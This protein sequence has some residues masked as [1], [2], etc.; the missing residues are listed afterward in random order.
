MQQAGLGGSC[1]SSEH[2]P[3]TVPGKRARSLPSIQTQLKPAQAVGVGRLGG[4][5][6][7]IIQ[8][9]LPKATLMLFSI[10]ILQKKSLL[11]TAVLWGQ[12]HPV[13]GKGSSRP[14]W[15]FN[16]SATVVYQHGT[17]FN[18]MA[19]KQPHGGASTLKHFLQGTT[20]VRS[21]ASFL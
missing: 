15:A 8:I 10:L 17:L 21:R 9:F 6:P 19:Q 14:C 4:A 7:F 13:Q 3:P 11:N 2:C 12:Q 20:Q 18:T 16:T 1:D 5:E